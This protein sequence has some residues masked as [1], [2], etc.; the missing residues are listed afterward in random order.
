MIGE[1]QLQAID[2]LAT[3]FH[4]IQPQ[5]PNKKVVPIEVTTVAPLRVPITVPSL[6]VYM[7]VAPPRVI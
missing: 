3:F 6:R 2:R 5:Q 1:S 7:T 4:N